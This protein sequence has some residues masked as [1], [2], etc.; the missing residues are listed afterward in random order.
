MFK[1]GDRVEIIKA[2]PSINFPLGFKTIVTKEAQF[3]HVIT[4]LNDKG[5]E[6][7]INQCHVDPYRPKV[8]PKEYYNKY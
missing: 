2:F 4:I 5:R 3:G 6:Q 8:N 1:V 7:Q